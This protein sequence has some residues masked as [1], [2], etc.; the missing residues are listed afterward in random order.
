[1]MQY[2]YGNTVTSVAELKDLCAKKYRAGD[3]TVSNLGPLLKIFIS[4]E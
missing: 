4:P 2:H 1:M 3:F